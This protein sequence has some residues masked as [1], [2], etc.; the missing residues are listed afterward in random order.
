MHVS[1]AAID[2]FDC[3]VYVWNCVRFYVLLYSVPS[4][5]C[6]KCGNSERCN[7]IISLYIYYSYSK[8]TLVR[9]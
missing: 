5:S 8:Y 1:C 3:Q 4:A 7:I 2:E 9:G 6:S